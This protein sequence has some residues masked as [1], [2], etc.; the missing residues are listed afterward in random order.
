MRILFVEH[1]EIFGGGQVVLLNLL[2]EWEKQ[3]AAVEPL[4]VCPPRAALAEHLRTLEIPR[5][6]VELGAIEKTRSVVWNLAQRGAPTMRLLR[7]LRAFQPGAVCAN[8]AYALLAC[9]FAAKI[10]RVPLVWFEHNNKP[11]PDERLV[12]WL[13]Q[14][15]RCAVVVSRMLEDQ[16]TRLVPAS[17][18]K[19]I[20]IHNGADGEQ[21]DAAKHKAA[22]VR[23]EFGWGT[24]ARVIGTVARLAP[25]KNISLVLDAAQKI[26]AEMPDVKFLLVGDGPLRVA[27]QDRVA[28]DAALRRACVFTGQRNDVAR[29]LQALDI[30]VLASNAEAFPLA[31]IEAMAAGL[32]VIA[33]D[34]GGVREAVIH[35]ETGWLVPSGDVDALTKA[36]LALLRDEKKRR[37]FGAHAR[38]R[39]EQAF[40]LE[41]QATQMQ[42]VLERAALR[43]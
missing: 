20:L 13:L 34:V 22:A 43:A 9:V 31:I 8:G 35:D 18:E 23:A 25:E 7:T 30:F 26:L 41:Q 38:T 10:A 42:N 40:T 14:Q 17:P 36:L 12:R 6:L 39:A 27:L 24:E 29:L 11:L 19:I 21:F 33:T 2:R 4:V 15:V 16:F 1:K 32:A 5:E 3:R 37:L 28:A